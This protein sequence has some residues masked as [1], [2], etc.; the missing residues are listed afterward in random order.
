MADGNRGNLSQ[1]GSRE[2]ELQTKASLIERRDAG[3]EGGMQVEKG[4][5]GI[6]G[7][8][9]ERGM[10]ASCKKGYSWFHQTQEG[11]LL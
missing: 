8:L 3:G 5:A 10:L 2:M 9:V 7:M 6:V 1:D 11:S 4:D